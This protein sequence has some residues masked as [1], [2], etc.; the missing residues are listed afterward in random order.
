M[1]L[2]SEEETIEA[3]KAKCEAITATDRKVPDGACRWAEDIKGLAEMLKVYFSIQA[4]KVK[5]AIT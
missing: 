3:I 4:I 5:E 1:P 2:V